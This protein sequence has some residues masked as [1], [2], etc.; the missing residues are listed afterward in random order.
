M[1]VG[2]RLSRTTKALHGPRRRRLRRRSPVYLAPEQS[3]NVK[4]MSQEQLSTSSVPVR[5]SEP[6]SADADTASTSNA[7]AARGRVARAASARIRAASPWVKA[8]AAV[9]AV[10]VAMPAVLSALRPSARQTDPSK[11]LTTQYGSEVAAYL[12]YA[13]APV[14]AWITATLALSPVVILLL[15]V[16]VRQPCNRAVQ[17]PAFL[18]R[19]LAGW[20][21]L[22]ASTTMLVGI[23]LAAGAESWTDT[24]PWLWRIAAVLAA[25][26]LAPVGVACSVVASVHSNKR[27]AALGCSVAVAMGGWGVLAP[28]PGVPIAPGAI[29][30]ALL[31]GRAGIPA[32]AVA[33]ALSW[34]LVG[35][36]G[37][38]AVVHVRAGTERKQFSA[39]ST[40]RHRRPR[41]R[42]RKA[43][44][45][46]PSRS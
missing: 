31:T 16:G 14:L 41:K 39:E 3:R 28:G 5:R 13:P 21:L 25:T 9:W 8:S 4:G 34:L 46:R 30:R 36:L 22:H 17:L 43:N 6:D 37:G 44:A 35:G 33:A 2:S 40:R 23:A 19:V 15:A 32:S 27:A 12:S 20:L 42:K 11:L 7:R 26:G 45:L 29:D 24:W 18:A 10:F 1:R 38:A